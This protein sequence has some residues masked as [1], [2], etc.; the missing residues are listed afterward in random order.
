MVPTVVVPQTL[1][2][3]WTKLLQYLYSHAFAEFQLHH[4]SHNKIISVAIAKTV[5]FFRMIRTSNVSTFENPVLA[6]TQS[7]ESGDSCE[8]KTLLALE[9]F[10]LSSTCFLSS[11]D[12]DLCLMLF[13]PFFFMRFSYWQGMQ[14][15]SWHFIFKWVLIGY[16]SICS[17]APSLLLQPIPVKSIAPKR[18]L[19]SEK[20]C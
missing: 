6:F 4:F 13:I 3:D 15:W 20:S 10:C 19:N 2:K 14:A 11:P 18:A 16:E 1:M 7:I 5:V 12:P 9:E 17:N 8:E